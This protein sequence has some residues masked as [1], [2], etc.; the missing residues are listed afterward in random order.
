M[1][2]VEADGDVENSYDYDVFGAIRASSGSE[3]N[4][5]KF[6]GEQTDSTTGLQYLRARYYG[7]RDREIHK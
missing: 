4:V 1:K 5:F 6:T 7:W 3:P 2:L